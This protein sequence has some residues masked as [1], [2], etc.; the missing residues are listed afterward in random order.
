[1]KTESALFVHDAD[2]AS[3][4]DLKWNEALSARKGSQGLRFLA[5]KKLPLQK[6]VPSRLLE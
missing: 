2:I 6:F 1:M 3:H 4:T 5:I